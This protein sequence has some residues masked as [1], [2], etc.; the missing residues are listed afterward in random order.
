MPPL[1]YVSP[2]HRI[3]TTL[4]LP[5][6]LAILLGAFLL[7]P[8]RAHAV[9]QCS[10]YDYSTFVETYSNMY[11]CNNNWDGLGSWECLECTG[12]HYR[13]FPSCHYFGQYCSDVYSEASYY[14]QGYYYAQGY[15]YGEGYYQGYYY[16]QGYYQGYYYGQGYYQSYYYGQG[17]Y[18]GYY[19]GQGY[20]QSTYYAEGYYAPVCSSPTVTI[21]STP[22]RVRVGNTVQLKI[23]ATGI[24]TS[25]SVTGPGV[26]QTLTPTSCNIGPTTITTPAITKQS[27]YTV[28]C[29]SAA[30]TTKV[31]VNTIPR[32]FIF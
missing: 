16:G 8:P 29:D 10:S 5:F 1:V 11:T 31:I 24:A 17:Y 2:S 14:S 12:A 15:Y 25:C 28:S 23:T 27:T 9:I 22:G 20:Y 32:F 7:F 26:S 13:V 21:T 3:S 4:A 6:V 19:Y 18:Q 30:A